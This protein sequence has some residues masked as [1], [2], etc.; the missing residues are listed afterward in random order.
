MN[1]EDPNHR[2]I[3]IIRRSSG[4]EEGHHGGAWK[5]AFAD[6]MTAMMALFLVLWLINAAN[7]ETKRAVASYFNPVKLVDRNRSAKGVNDQRGGPTSDP[8]ESGVEKSEDKPSETA[9]DMPGSKVS[10]DSRIESEVRFFS[11]PQEQLDAIVA[12]AQESPMLLGSAPQPQPDAVV[13][14]FADPFGP[15]FWNPTKGGD[16]NELPVKV[17]PV[18]PGDVVPPSQP[19]PDG[20]KVAAIQQKSGAERQ[21]SAKNEE[22]KAREKK[23]LAEVLKAE[24]QKSL[25][26]STGSAEKLGQIIEVKSVDEGI[27]IS[28]TD[29]LDVP[30]FEV[31]SAIPEAP[32]VLAVD[33]IA[34]AVTAKPGAIH[35]FGHTDGREYKSAADGNWRLST[36]R[37]K[38]TYFMLLHGGLPEQRVVEIAGFADRKLRIME[39]PLA[40]QNRRIEIL[41]ETK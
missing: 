32:L 39:D 35:I 17:Q 19:V 23:E 20:Q 34:K 3:I 12:A 33:A 8:N 26:E 21:A 29:G 41:L 2:E 30:M 36:D 10:H 6:F 4:E 15:D 14:N 25:A 13:E 40:D 37:A 16:Q 5:I 1:S 28:V 9:P 27:L 18:D 31:G 22:G 11:S 24:V 7:E 38:S